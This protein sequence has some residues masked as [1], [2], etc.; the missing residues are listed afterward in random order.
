MN[1]N[2]VKVKAIDVTNTD[3]AGVV[4]VR[5]LQLGRG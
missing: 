3:T 5:R 4:N 1:N 2:G